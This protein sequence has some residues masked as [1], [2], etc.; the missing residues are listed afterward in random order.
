MIG[1]KC[2]SKAFMS[3]LI[4]TSYHFTFDAITNHAFLR[5]TLSTFGKQKSNHGRM[6]KYNSTSN[7][8]KTR[9]YFRCLIYGDVMIA[10][11]LLLYS[12][13]ESTHSWHLQCLGPFS[14]W[15]LAHS[16]VDKH[17]SG[18]V[19]FNGIH[20][21]KEAKIRYL[22]CLWLYNSSNHMHDI[23]HQLKSRRLGLGPIT[24]HIIIIIDIWGFRQCGYTL[25]EWEKCSIAMHAYKHL[26]CWWWL[27]SKGESGGGG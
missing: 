12:C 25:R 17:M 23:V 21:H 15:C 13:P 26:A 1:C 4:S 20:W 6:D 10:T 14:L 8:S 3:Y 22:I 2:H 24:S 16:P 7:I 19:P 5:G 9:L 27:Y 11:P 18:F